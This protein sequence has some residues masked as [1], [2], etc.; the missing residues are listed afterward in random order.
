M[1]PVG[2]ESWASTLNALFPWISSKIV[3]FSF[4]AFPGTNRLDAAS[5]RLFGVIVEK[6]CNFLPFSRGLGKVHAMK[7]STAILLAQ[8]KGKS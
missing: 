7:N 8:P 4:G 5:G 2:T 1:P 3:L 6:T